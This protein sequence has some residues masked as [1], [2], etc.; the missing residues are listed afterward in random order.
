[1]IFTLA[2]TLGIIL[3][4]L[5]VVQTDLGPLEFHRAK[6]SVHFTTW[7]NLPQTQN[8]ISNHNQLQ[9]TNDDLWNRE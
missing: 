4:T 7:L 8:K 6:A 3:P 5:K 9:T 2:R 1:M